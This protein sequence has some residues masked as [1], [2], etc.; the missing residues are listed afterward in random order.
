MSRSALWMGM[1]I[2]GLL[3]LALFSPSLSDLKEELSDPNTQ[4][5]WYMGRSNGF[6]AYWLLFLSVVAGLSAFPVMAAGIVVL[7]QRTGSRK[8]GLP[9]SQKREGADMGGRGEELVGSGRP[10]NS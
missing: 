9:P 4:I 6:V 1:V 8:A 5:F 3:A 10:S 2:G 7:V